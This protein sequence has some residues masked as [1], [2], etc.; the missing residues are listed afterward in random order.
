MTDSIMGNGSAVHESPFTPL[1]ALE[2]DIRRFRPDVTCNTVIEHAWSIGASDIFIATGP[3]NVDISVRHLGVVKHISSLPGEAGRRLMAFIRALAGM[4]TVE[5]RVPL[6]GRWTR[7]LADGHYIDLRLCMMPT[8]HGESFAIRILDSR[9]QLR[10]LDQLGLVGPQL[11]LLEQL[12]RSPS[13]LIIVCGPTG[14]GKTTTLYSC[15]QQLN[16]GRRKIHTIEDPVEYSIP[17]LRQSQVDENNGTDFYQLL[18]S[19]LRQGP[20]VI[21]IGEIRDK[22]TAETAVRA[23]N[24]GQ[25]VFATLHAPVAAAALQ[26]MLS[27]GIAPHFLCTS[28]LGVIGQRLLRTLSPVSRLP[29][30]MSAAPEIF[31]EVRQYLPKDSGTTIYAANDDEPDGGY[32]GR[33]G[34]FEIMKITPRIRASLAAYEPAGAIAAKAIEEG[35]LDFRRAALIKVALGI[36]SFDEVSRVVPSGDTWVDD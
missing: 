3:D 27:Q 19:V 36:T 28:V 12:L 29:M 8:I 25:L 9:S 24:S 4:D 13:G 18:R 35:M 22:A 34:V 33:T 6:D 32:I 1:I 21:M 30:D 11:G 26:S 7:K 17:G 31:S 10:P 20:D 5:R 2:Q 15:L 16:D 14:A 23:A